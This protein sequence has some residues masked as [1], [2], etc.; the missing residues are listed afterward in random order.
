[1]CK[2][3]QVAGNMVGHGRWKGFH[4]DVNAENSLK[5][6]HTQKKYS[7]SKYSIMKGFRCKIIQRK[8]K[9]KQKYKKSEGIIE[10]EINKDVNNIIPRVNHL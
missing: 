5:K 2:E 6:L 7:I 4:D 1:V 8:L 10:N 9:K 3:V